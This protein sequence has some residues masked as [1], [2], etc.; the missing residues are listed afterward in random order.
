VACVRIQLNYESA[1]FFCV[2]D[3]YIVSQ[4]VAYVARID[5][6]RGGKPNRRDGVGRAW[7][8]LDSVVGEHY[9]E[10]GSASQ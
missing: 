2:S 6:T 8:S 5:D 7:R 4:S 10:R 3:T 9:N 1:G